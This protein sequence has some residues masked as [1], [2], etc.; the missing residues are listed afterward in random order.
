MTSPA[1]RHEAEERLLKVLREEQKRDY[2]DRSVMGGLD[3]LLKNFMDRLP[4]DSAV[5]GL[6]LELP[7]KGYASLTN[8][9]RRRWAD[10]VSAP[11]A[12][13]PGATLPR[14]S[15]VTSLR[16]SAVSAA[17]HSTD[18]AGLTTPIE[19]L[20]IRETT[21]EKIKKIRR[22]VGPI[23]TVYDLITHYPFRHIDYG[24]LAKIATLQPGDRT[25][26]ARVHTI[27]AAF[28]GNRGRPVRA[29]LTDGFGRIDAVWFNQSWVASQLKPGK[30]YVF[31]G[32]VGYFNGRLQFENAEYE[33]ANEETLD[34]IDRG[35][36]IPVYPSTAGLPQRT[37]RRA[38]SLAL[39]G[40]LHLVPE[41]LPARIREATNLEDHAAALSDYHYPSNHEAFERA[42]RRLG[43]DEFFVKQLVVLARR[44]QWQSGPEA[45]RLVA[46]PAV[47]EDFLGTLPFV[48]TGAQRRSLGEVLADLA[49]S[50]PMSRLLQGDVGSGKTVV[51]TAGAVTTIANGYQ[52]LLMAP[53]EILAEQHF[54]TVSGLLGAEE[55]EPSIAASEPAFLRRPIRIAHLT[56]GQKASAKKRIREVIA[57]G[58]IDLAVG[59]HALIEESV[60]FARLGFIVIDEQHRFGVVQR[61][62]LKKKGQSPHLLVM[63]ATPIPRTLSLT[64]YGDLDN[65]V[66]DEL[67]P[68]RQRIETRY[69]SPHERPRAYN[70]VREQVQQG[71]QA[72]VICPLVEESEAIEAKAAVQEHRR[73]GSEIFP[74]LKLSLL[75]GRMKTSEKDSVMQEF[76]EGRSDILVSTSVI[77]VGIDIPN[78]TVMMIEGADRFGL[79]QL[80]QFRGRVGRGAD[81]SYCLLLADD[82]S[83]QAKERLEIVVEV[84]DGFKLAEEDLRIRGEGEYYGVRQSGLADF[85][86]ARLTDEDLLANARELAERTLDEN[87]NLEGAEYGELRRQVSDFAASRNILLAFH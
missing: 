55:E 16:P 6:I 63:T 9:E 43:F 40:F 37:L 73:L 64:V 47:L 1:A 17:S 26:L 27:D 10:K 69:V 66:I 8:E 72:F 22:T 70:F 80:H 32:K 28:R 2:D 74:D 11:A 48:L 30:E 42:Q 35:R 45:P 41:L 60:E 24:H 12:A 75:H 68:G 14:R 67:P 4:L 20:S 52:A 21:A 56:G 36:L 51:A 31:S 39:K 78:A 83:D 85:Q 77:E 19:R 25:T 50:V 82:P 3:R 54:R 79:S 71:R 61:D 34:D 84:H 46:Q 29:V 59:T 86:V 13:R 81:Q 65:S 15:T 58:E 57:S 53:T 33:P 5:R 49:L 62:L 44:R 18:G 7:S 76:R 38:V 87:P 23:T